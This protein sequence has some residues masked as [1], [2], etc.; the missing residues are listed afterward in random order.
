[1]RR[2][3]CFSVVLLFFVVAVTRLA[4]PSPHD[5]Y[6][7]ARASVE[8]PG[9]LERL[10]FLNLDIVKVE[11]GKYLEF[12]THQDQL[13]Q[14]RGLGFRVEVVIEDME[15]H[16]ARD[17]KGDNFGDLYT[18]SEMI[19]DLDAI[20]AAYPNITTAKTSLGTSHLGWDVW[21]IK[22]SDNPD[23]QEDEPEILFDGLHHAREPITVS[24]LLNTLRYLC[25]N[26]GTDPH[27][28]SLVDHRQ[29]W[30]VPIVNPDGYLYNEALYPAG[31]GMWRK[32]RRDNGGGACGVDLNRN[33]PYEWGGA[34]SSSDP[35][36][37]LYRGPYAGSEPEV[38]AMMNF[39]ENHQFVTQNS[40]HSVV[41][42]IL[43]PWGYSTT[44]CQEDSL[45]RA[46]GDEMAQDS[47]YE[48]GTVWDVLIYLVSG[49]AF[50]WSYGDTSAK[51]RIHAFSTEVAGSGFW[52]A[53]SEVPGL[54]QENLHSDLYLI[55]IAGA[56][57][58]YVNH[59]IQDTI[60]R[61]NGQ[62]D[63]GESVLM[64]VIL[65][66][67]SPLADAQG[68]SAILTTGDP[69][70][71]LSEAQS[72]YGDI[73][74]GATVHNGTD[75]FA[76]SVEALCP[77]GHQIPFVVDISAN[78]GALRFTEEFEVTV[79]QS[80]VIH[81]NDF[82]TGPD[83]TQDPTHTASTGDFVR[84]DPSP[85]EYQP[86]DD[87]TPPPGV[88]AWVTGQNTAVGTDDVDAGIAATRSPAIDLSAYSFAHLS[89][90]YFHGQRDTGDD[91]IGDFFRIDL[92]NDGGS[93]FPV[94]LVLVGDVTTSPSWHS[95][96]V[97]LEDVIALTDQMMLRVQAA[98]GAGPGMGDIVEG[99]IDDLLIVSGTGNIPPPAPTPDEP[100][101]G[102]TVTT[103]APILAIYNV[104]DP[105][106]DPVTYGFC[107]YG[108]S[109]L[110]D[111]VAS[112]PEVIAGMGT[113]SWQVDPPLDSEGLYWWR[114]FAADTVEWGPACDPIGFHFLSPGPAAVSHLKALMADSCLALIWSPVTEADHYI[115][116]RDSLTSFV[117]SPL[118][119]VG[120]ALDT[121]Y[122]DCD[123]VGKKAFYVVRAVDG[124]G[125][126]SEDSHRV[127]QFPRALSNQDKDHGPFSILNER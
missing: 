21:A 121:M 118:D 90:M 107:V 55:Q 50:D 58:S 56:Y 93:S 108:D 81:A 40:Y 13:A 117:P 1:M 26:Y 66:N 114:A 63:P 109:L 7:L 103:S 48:V 12:V 91:P 17:R 8:R 82:E 125:L 27:I 94:N 5:P 11:K 77:Q 116:Y 31:G 53:D 28:T 23:I 10:G 126:K 111:L 73:L 96:E 101:Q 25:E 34:G 74:A 41:G 20:H 70:V 22:V 112:S 19:D 92:S 87:T 38:Q 113:T 30:F 115:I 37:N 69:Y 120:V 46:L 59:A 33:Y 43:F 122:V 97:D 71:Q 72:D 84:V 57:V 29:I 100:G 16:Y 75:P 45:L 61:G 3:L 6:I 42:A 4:I 44:Y 47:G 83:W 15:A 78:G 105:E 80:P 49:G 85:T 79:G 39:I 124:A 104:Q 76:F 98:D 32:N 54:C 14:L 99:G 102:D 110:T 9:D 18:Y 89:L 62:V 119:S 86:G 127:G 35:Y 52:P 106:G 36:D 2:W 68:V 123:P 88:H 24:V 64:T 60:A 51:P 65:K 67:D 95:L